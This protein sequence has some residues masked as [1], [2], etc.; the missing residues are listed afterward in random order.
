MNSLISSRSQRI[1]RSEIFEM[2]AQA[3]KYD[4]VIN[5][6]VGEPH[7]NTPQEITDYA[8]NRAKEGYTHYTVNAGDLEVRKA[9]AK[10]LKQENNIDVNPEK[11]II[12]TVG[13]IEAI[14]LALMAL[15]ES[16]DE[17]IFQDPSWVNYEAQIKLMNAIPVRV[18]VKEEN[19]FAL[20]ADDIEKRVTEKSKILMINSPNNPTGGAIEKQE[21][22]KIA[23][24]AHE[25][26]IIILTDETYEKLCYDIEHFS[27]GSIEKYQ[28]NIISIFSFS[29]AYAMTGWRI[30]FAAGP[31]EI[32]REMVKIHDSVGLCTPTISQA[33]ALKALHMDDEVVKEMAESYRENRDL[34]VESLNSID[35]FSSIYPRGTFY[36]FV[37]IENITQNS[38]KLARDMLDKV[39]VMTVAGSSFGSIGEGYLRFSYANSKENIKKG[40]DRISRYVSNYL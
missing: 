9:I 7:Y 36:S 15:V 6:G 33:A 18:P 37:N 27:P 5:F 17:V 24:V 1:V 35:G 26:D 19:N 40:V 2:L 38:L 3:E 22:V 13:A 29:K 16:G 30:G 4:D 23:E 34:L 14:F 11:Q 21:L 31:A 32:I 12:I 20:R 28:E 25:N 10:K 39:Q 8:F